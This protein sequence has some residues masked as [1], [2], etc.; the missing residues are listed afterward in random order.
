MRIA[1]VLALV[2]WAQVPR[3]AEAQSASKP[4][5]PV[6]VVEVTAEQVNSGYRV[7]GEILPLRTSVVGSGADGRVATFH[8]E[9]GQSVKVGQPLATLL[10]QTLQIELAAAKAELKLYQQEY[11]EVN[12]GS[13][14]EEIAEAEALA[15]AA[16]IARKNAG[17]QLQRLSGL[18][19]SGAATP[20]DLDNAR[21]M[22]ESAS[23]R[24]QAAQALLKKIIAGPRKEQVAQRLAQVELQEQRVALINDRIEKHTIRAPFDG[25]VS[26]EFTEVGAWISRGDP[27]AQIVQLDEVEVQLPVTADYV[28]K[29]EL[30]RT[31][32]V[33]FPELPSR[34]MTGTID[35]IVPFSESRSR[36]FPV[37]IRLRNEIRDTV[38]VLMAGM[39]A[40]VELPAGALRSLPVVPKDA[41][42]LNDQ[43]KYIVIVDRD[44]Q[45]SNVGVARRV[46]VDL[47]VA[48]GTNIQVL[49]DI[50]AGDLVVVVGN[51]RLSDGD[52][53]SLVRR[54]RGDVI[55]PV[56]VEGAAPSASQSP[57]E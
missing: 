34:L 24:S 29:L 17:I 31:V 54:D 4:P 12:N 15:S 50:T 51:E 7:V 38:P 37:L 9:V 39:L 19:A 27:V 33:E 28:S 11:A 14:P 13:R 45:D 23:A 36:T 10:T 25:F 35:R 44:P 56:A 53:V 42:V 40:R 52:E 5:P 49:G 46:D 20:A 47:G 1:L 55:V 8:V 43:S 2:Y 30:G 57:S 41:L 3:P 32:R 6:V 48:V 16:E 22:A 26:A 18:T 21:E